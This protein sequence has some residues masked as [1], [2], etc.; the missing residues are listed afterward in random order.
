MMLW[1]LKKKN[2]MKKSACVAAGAFCYGRA[3]ITN[4]SLIAIMN[5]RRRVYEICRGL[6]TN[7]DMIF[8][9][10]FTRPS[11]DQVY[12]FI[13]Y[14]YIRLYGYFSR[15]FLCYEIM[16]KRLR[17]SDFHETFQKCPSCIYLLLWTDHFRVEH[18]ER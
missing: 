13:M 11:Y 18:S 12:P 14:L 10:N 8:I 1:K 3:V 16:S 5:A 17:K 7:F 2:R 6:S 9:G 4:Q 15:C